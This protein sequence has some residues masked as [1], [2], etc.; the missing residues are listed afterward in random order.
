MRHIYVH[1]PFCRRRCSYCDFS[2]AVRKE[3]PAAGFVADI[4]K[5]RELCVERGEWD[6]GPLETL[7]LGGGTPSLL[8]PEQLK[9]LAQLFDVSRGPVL[10]GTQSSIAAQASRG[11]VKTPENG[12]RRSRLSQIDSPPMVLPHNEVTLEANPD[13]VASAAVRSWVEAGITR[14]SLGVQPF[15]PAILSWMHR[16]HTVQQSH[17]ASGILKQPGAISVSFDLIFGLPEQLQHDF[18]QAL[19]LALELDPD[20]LSVYGLT[21]EPRTPLARWISR[22]SAAV[23]TEGRWASEFLLAHDTLV[24]A[25]Y[26]HYEVS[27]YAMPGQRAVHNRAYWTGMPYA[28]LGPSAHRFDGDTRRW[29]VAP[30]A[31]YHR[32]MSAQQDPTAECET[33]SAEQ[34]RLEDVYLALRT[35]DG[36]SVE[37]IAELNQPMVRRAS[38]MG[39]MERVVAP[40]INPPLPCEGGEAGAARFRLTPRGWLRLDAIIPALTTSAQGG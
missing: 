14:V 34:R 18:R 36:L 27:N 13:D 16:S 11:R 10:E 12:S 22:G 24:A 17:S 37:E 35:S 39:W 28:G 29:N 15:A 5:E 26:E 3:V 6:D 1:V 7:Y 31:E 25:G 8:P 9:Q 30:W 20:H 38:E 21:V 32:R 2:I 23:A 4:R 40:G 33:L 19:E